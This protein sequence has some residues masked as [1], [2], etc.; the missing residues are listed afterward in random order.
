MKL[1]CA[2]GVT[3]YYIMLTSETKL[4]RRAFLHTVMLNVSQMYFLNLPSV[5]I[6][7]GCGIDHL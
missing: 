3:L 5:F 6:R 4:F 2:F 1:H 7:I